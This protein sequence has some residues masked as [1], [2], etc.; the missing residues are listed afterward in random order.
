[1]LKKL[2]FKQICAGLLSLTLLTMAIIPHIGKQE[3]KVFSL[4]NLK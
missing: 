4:E 2:K 1:M 3:A